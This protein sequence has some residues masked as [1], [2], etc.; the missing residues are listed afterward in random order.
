LLVEFSSHRNDQ[1]QQKKEA[2]FLQP[3]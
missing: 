1:I 3:S 2:I